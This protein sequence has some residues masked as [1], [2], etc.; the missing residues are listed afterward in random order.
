MKV[1]DALINQTDLK[2]RYT[3]SPEDY[4]NLPW[5]E[6]KINA[7]KQYWEPDVKKEDGSFDIP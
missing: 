7:Y 5:N 6:N 3:H 2:I 4:L 1:G